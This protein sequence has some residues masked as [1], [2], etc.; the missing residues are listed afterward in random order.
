MNDQMR[1]LR[2]QGH[3]DINTM[4]NIVFE[5]NQNLI[6]PVAFFY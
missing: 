5:T 4:I 2:N 1:E 6:H 3:T